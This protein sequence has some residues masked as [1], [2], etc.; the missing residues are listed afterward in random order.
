MTQTP[1]HQGHTF[2]FVTKGATTSAPAIIDEDGNFQITGPTEITEYDGDQ[3][4]WCNDC[5][6]YLYEDDGL[7]DTW[8]VLG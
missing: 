5:G 2:S 8:V 1:K 6:I 7:S 4:P 3:Y